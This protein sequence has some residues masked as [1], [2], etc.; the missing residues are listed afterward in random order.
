MASVVRVEYY[1][2][3]IEESVEISFYGDWR[4]E[5]MG[6]RSKWGFLVTI[7]GDLPYLVQ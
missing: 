2:V 6:H 7:N 3:H 4:E 1:T 5:G